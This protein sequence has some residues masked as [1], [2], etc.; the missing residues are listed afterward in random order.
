MGLKD[1]G[2]LLPGFQADFA[3]CGDAFP[4]P[5]MAGNLLDQL[6]V[7]GKS[8]CVTDVSVGGRLRLEAGTLT[9]LDEAGI[10]T[11]MRE[12]AGDFWQGVR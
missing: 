11:R 6:V 12:C 3:V 2:R 1:C 9:G 5:L 10:H 4:T 7:H 8:Q